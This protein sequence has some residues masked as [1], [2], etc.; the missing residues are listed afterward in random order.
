[1]GLQFENLVLNNEKLILKCLGINM[2]E[3]VYANPY[4][5]TKT[6]SREGCQI[7]YMVQTRYNNV[8]IFEF[9]FSKNKI[10]C[11]VI[12][13]VKEKI[14]RLKLPRNFSYRPVLIHVNGVTS[15]LIDAQY[16]ASVIDYSKF[17]D[18]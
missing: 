17:L 8:Y 13:E 5:Q 18:D 1:M 15:D 11:S 16:F 6:K 12:E 14:K 10:G 3:V 9:K 4:Y 2:S 7:D